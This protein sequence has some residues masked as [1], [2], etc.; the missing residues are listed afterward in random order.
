MK[1]VKNR[2]YPGFTYKINSKSPLF[3]ERY[4]ENSEITIECTAK[5][6]FGEFF[7][8]EKDLTIKFY[9]NR[10]DEIP[11]GKGDIFYGSVRGAPDS[12][13]SL[14]HESEIGDEVRE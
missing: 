5:E 1:T 3:I 6:K 10:L 14:V 7:M 11:N 8:R 4:G 12:S 13:Y 2:P 9:R